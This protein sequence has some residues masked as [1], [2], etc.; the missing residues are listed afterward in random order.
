MI[1]KDY[2]FKPLKTKNG[3]YIGVKGTGKVLGTKVYKKK[4]PPK[5]PSYLA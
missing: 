5:K 1:N 3:S 2:K 4:K